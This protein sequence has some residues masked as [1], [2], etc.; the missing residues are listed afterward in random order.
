MMTMTTVQGATEDVAL[1][2]RGFAPGPPWAGASGQSQWSLAR[3]PRRRPRPAA[4]RRAGRREPLRGASQPGRCL[5][6][7]RAL[8]GGRL[9]VGGFVGGRLLGPRGELGLQPLQPLAAEGR[10]SDRFGRGVGSLATAGQK[11][12]ARSV[13][14]TRR[15]QVIGELRVTG[16]G[17][18]VETDRTTVTGA[19]SAAEQSSA[20]SAASAGEA[21]A[22]RPATASS[23]RGQD[24]GELLHEGQVLRGLFLHDCQTLRRTLVL[25]SQ[26]DRFAELE[27]L[28]PRNR[29]DPEASTQV[30][31]SPRVGRFDLGHLAILGSGAGQ[32]TVRPQRWPGSGEPT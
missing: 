23:S 14:T 2:Y 32:V 3:R 16:E 28:H 7:E 18:R 1:D 9:P 27:P 25:G 19:R 10:P 22:I 20:K 29:L 31:M 24:R 21:G 17:P 13:V 4:R 12:V 26:L 6:P 5:E 11:S 15:R 30:Q 8:V